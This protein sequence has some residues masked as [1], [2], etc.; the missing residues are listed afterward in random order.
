MGLEIPEKEQLQS[1]QPKFRLNMDSR[2]RVFRAFNFKEA[3]KVPAWFGSSPEF[4]QKAMNALNMDEEG[5]RK[6]FG[7]DFRRVYGVYQEPGYQVSK[8][9][10]WKSPFG[11]ERIG[12][13]FGQP[14]THPLKDITTV[15]EA[16]DYY[17]PNPDWVNVSN[18]KNDADKYHREFAI[19]GG[20]WSPFWHDAVDLFGM[21]ELFIKMY[22]Y[23]EVVKTVIDQ[24]VNYYYVVN[25]H[26]FDAA[27]DSIDVF[28]IGNDF[29]SQTGPLLG[30]DL[31]SEFLLPSLKKLIDLGH[32]YNHKVM[33][34]CCGSI[35]LLLPLMI[36][37]GLDGIHPL[38]PDC[39]GMEPSKLKKDFGDKI[40]L[41]G[42][43]DS[44]NILINGK[45]DYVK[46]ETI[47]ILDIMAPG[48][49]YVAGASHDYILEETPFENVLAM[50]DAISEY[51][52]A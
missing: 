35:R 40:L 31:F 13:G 1:K 39:Y 2:E 34:H 6:R 33:L 20:D 10:T 32:S 14:T 43:I 3:D 52:L 26:I 50:F 15:K 29:G 25:E 21:E 12:I 24:I 28:F 19:L 47:R 11:V 27:G 37:A 4:L 42:G 8:T 38:Q 51:Q 17:S 30:I 5:V 49:G 46:R 45:S 7:D 16:F 23:P 9:A 44:H 22:E 18:I 48:G 41:N 36:E